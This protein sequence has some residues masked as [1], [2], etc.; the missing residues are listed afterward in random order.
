MDRV[1]EQTRTSGDVASLIEGHEKK[2]RL[3]S[4]ICNYMLIY[5]HREQEEEQRESSIRVLPALKI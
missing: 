2:L 5:S 3:L 4:Y 1:V